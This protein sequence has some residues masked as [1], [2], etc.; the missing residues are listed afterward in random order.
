MVRVRRVVHPPA[1]VDEAA[2][3][4]PA[5]PLHRAVELVVAAARGRQ[6]EQ[7]AGDRVAGGAVERAGGVEAG[8][9]ERRE[10]ELAGQRGVAEQVQLH[11]PEGAAGV[12]RVVALHHRQRVAVVVDVGA[13]L[14]RREAAVADAD[15]VLERHAGQRRGLVGAEVGAR[16]AQLAC[17]VRAVAERG[18]VV[19]DPV[20]AGGELVDGVAPE[21]VRVRQR[22]VLGAS[23]SKVW[24]LAN[25]PVRAEIRQA[26]RQVLVG[27][28]EAEAAEDPVVV[29]EV[30][31]DAQVALVIVQRLH[32][33]GQVV[34]AEP[35]GEGRASA[36]GSAV[37]GQSDRCG[38]PG[39]GCPGTDR[40]S[41]DRSPDR[42]G[43]SP[44]RR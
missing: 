3:L 12:E 31:I 43:S 41:A 35:I 29:A 11:R 37:P 20:V 1:V 13:A 9:E 33:V 2:E 40:G 25:P 38:W 21:H 23:V 44:G 10:R 39:C 27:L 19:V 5:P 17:L 28:L 36:A 18:D 42:P 30:V 24:L 6:A 4:L 7:Q 15:E 14:E 26:G 32:R 34:A 22:D 8:G 16:D